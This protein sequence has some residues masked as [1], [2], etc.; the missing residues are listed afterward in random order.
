MELWISLLG[1]A[2]VVLWCAVCI[3]SRVISTDTSCHI[4][5]NSY[6]YVIAEE[7]AR[8]KDLAKITRKYLSDDNLADSS[9]AYSEDNPP[10]G[11]W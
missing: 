5:G 3:Y 1:V 7:R 10:C 8:A 2:V 9:P 4:G 6:Y 11:G